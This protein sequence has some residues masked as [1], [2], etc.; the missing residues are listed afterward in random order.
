MEIHST[1]C[2]RPSKQ[3]LG[4]KMIYMVQPVFSG[5]R[6]TQRGNEKKRLPVV[7]GVQ[8][9]PHTPPA[10][11][12]AGGAASTHFCD[13]PSPAAPKDVG[14]DRSLIVPPPTPAS[15]PFLLQGGSPGPSLIDIQPAKP[16][17]WVCFPKKPNLQQKQPSFS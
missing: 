16:H 8:L 7:R 12:R 1:F 15:S 10:V 11:P 13:Q 2:F 17:L 3:A 14:Q 4:G 9:P 6:C 5:L